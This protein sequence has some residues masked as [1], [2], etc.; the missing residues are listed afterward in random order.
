MESIDNNLLYCFGG[1]KINSQFK[2]H[3]NGSLKYLTIPSFDETGLVKHCFTTRQGGVSQGIY[4][5]LNTS[6]VKND[7]RENVIENLR[8]VCSAID[9][10]YKKLVLSDQVHGDN[11]RI[12]TKADLGK[13]ITKESDIKEVDALITN[14]AGVPMITYYA[15]CV[16]VF[17][18]DRANKAVGLAHSGWK[19]TTLKIA[20]K[21]LAKMNEAFGTRP[22]DC[23][24]GI[25]PSIEMKCFEIREDA[26]ALFKQGFDNWQD[27]MYK[28]DKEHYTVDLWRAVEMTLLE[29]GVQ[30]KNITISGLCTVC[31]EDLFFSHRRDKGAT[32]SLSAIIELLPDLKD[33][34]I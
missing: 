3:T 16:P 17:F 32:G 6:L 4:D 15:D 24:V 5:N 23:L 30:E 11:V 9:I 28:K 19:G 26:A 27:F 29:A 18:L 8:R 22:E 12:V 1:I 2:I 7:K 13:G 25:G 34:R 10:D 20:A 21:T 33:I 14:E 31:N